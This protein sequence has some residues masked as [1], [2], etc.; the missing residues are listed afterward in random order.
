MSDQNFHRTSVTSQTSSL[1]TALSEL[2][3]DVEVVDME[4]G[5]LTNDRYAH[6]DYQGTVFYPCYNLHNNSSSTHTAD[7]V[8]VCV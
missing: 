4:D 2:A 5:A 6:S 1:H 3:G 7:G 8:C